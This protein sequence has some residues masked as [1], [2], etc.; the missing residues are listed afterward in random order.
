MKATE[1]YFPV[2]LFSM[3]CSVVHMKVTEQ[4]LNLFIMR[5]KVVQTLEPFQHIQVS[6]Y[7]KESPR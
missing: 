2:V 1:Q 3:I 4:Y 5:Y 7:S 6:E